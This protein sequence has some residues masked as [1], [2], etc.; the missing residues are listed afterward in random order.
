MYILVESSTEPTLTCTSIGVVC[1]SDLHSYFSILPPSPTTL[2]PHV[3]THETLPIV[4]GHEYVASPPSECAVLT[5]GDT[6]NVW[7]CD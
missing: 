5:R 7:H 2:E 3:V 4:M 6:Q 1:G